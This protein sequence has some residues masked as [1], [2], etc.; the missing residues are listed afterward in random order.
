MASSTRATPSGRRRTSTARPS[1]GER[2]FETRPLATS[3]SMRVVMV[4]EVTR[5]CCMSAPAESASSPLRRRAESMSNSQPSRPAPVKA[6]RRAL[7]R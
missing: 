5:V 1:R 7:S 4:P 2:D 6:S 3:L